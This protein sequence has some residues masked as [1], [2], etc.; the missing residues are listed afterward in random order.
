[1]VYGVS[2][3]NKLYSVAETFIF[4]IILPQFLLMSISSSSSSSKFSKPANLFEIL[5]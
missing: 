4:Y 2:D 1:M 3:H 5:T